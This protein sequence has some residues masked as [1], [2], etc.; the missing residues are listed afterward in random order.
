MAQP[1]PSYQYSQSLL[2]WVQSRLNILIGADDF[3]PLLL[4][5]DNH[6]L[7]SYCNDLLG[8]NSQTQS[9]VN[10]IIAKRSQEIRNQQSN[11]SNTSKSNNKNNNKKSRRSRGGN[12]RNKRSNNN[13]SNTM[14]LDPKQHTFT[15]KKPLKSHKQSQQQSNI[16]QSSYRQGGSMIIKHEPISKK[17]SRSSK[18]QKSLVK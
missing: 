7:Q 13:D 11:T 1:K 3:A 16:V 10:E 18:K 9:F 17:Q 12:N 2:A 14:T 8:E 4:S 5:L 6:E 15:T